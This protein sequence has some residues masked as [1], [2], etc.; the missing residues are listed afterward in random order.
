LARELRAVQE[1]A[2]LTVPFS[3]STLGVRVGALAYNLAE[4]MA[5]LTRGTPLTSLEFSSVDLAA[6]NG[7]QVVAKSGVKA[8]TTLPI[9]N[10]TDLHAFCPGAARPSL[11]IRDLPDDVAAATTI[12]KG[13]EKS[14]NDK[15]KPWAMGL[16]VILSVGAVV[17]AGFLFMVV[18]RERDGKPMFGPPMNVDGVVKEQPKMFAPAKH[19]TAIADDEDPTAI[20]DDEDVNC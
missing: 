16:I 19:S 6:T 10:G 1:R 9:W 8:Y 13:E 5:A 7:R 4:A 18:Q 14:N 11:E 17:L 12:T 2:F 20:A 15:I 3:G